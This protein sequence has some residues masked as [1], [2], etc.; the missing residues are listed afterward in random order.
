[1]ADASQYFVS[2]PHSDHCSPG[3]QAVAPLLIAGQINDLF[4]VEA[5][6]VLSFD[7]ICPNSF[8]RSGFLHEVV[9]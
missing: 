8:N 7:F 2:R 5:S 3:H 9:L 4:L 6:Y 1:M